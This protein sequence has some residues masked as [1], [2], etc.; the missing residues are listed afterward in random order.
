[1]VHGEA[2]HAGFVLTDR[3]VGVA[4]VT[5]ASDLRADVVGEQRRK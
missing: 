3:L 5:A 4:V 1:V 2:P